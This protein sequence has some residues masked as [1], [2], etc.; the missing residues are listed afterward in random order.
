MC[1]IYATQVTGSGLVTFRTATILRI[2]PHW[3]LH[4]Q[5]T[6]NKRSFA[7]RRNCMLVGVQCEWIR[8]CCSSVCIFC[9]SF[10]RQMN[11]EQRRTDNWQGKMVVP[12]EGTRHRHRQTPTWTW[13]SV[14]TFWRI[15]TW[16]CTGDHLPVSTRWCISVNCKEIAKGNDRQHTLRKYDGNFQMFRSVRSRPKLHS[17]SKW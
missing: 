4:A 6:S 1:N 15:I 3:H 16:V 5:S 11:M 7:E 14:V 17:Q 13:A 12:V 9:S 10:G 8:C 2:K